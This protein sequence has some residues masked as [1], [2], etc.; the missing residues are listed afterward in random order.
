MSAFPP[1]ADI[2]VG[3][4]P[5]VLDKDNDFACNSAKKGPKT[6]WLTFHKRRLEQAWE[7]FFWQGAPFAIHLRRVGRSMANVPLARD[8]ALF[9]DF[10]KQFLN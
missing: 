5:P 2:R 4:C 1:K 8:D 10:L 3:R 9:G 6:G 7:E